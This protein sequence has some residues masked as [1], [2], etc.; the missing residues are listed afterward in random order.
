MPLL[1]KDCKLGKGVDVG[2]TGLRI[3]AADT[4]PVC[5]LIADGASVCGIGV[6]GIVGTGTWLML[7]EVGE[8][9]GDS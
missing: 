2:P 6:K 3:G 1:P 7:I 9:S 5:V 4:V 8:G